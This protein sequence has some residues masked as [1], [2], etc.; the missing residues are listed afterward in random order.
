MKQK[1]KMLV[2]AAA[3]A[4]VGGVW[5]HEGWNGLVYSSSDE[6]KPGE[7][8]SRFIKA[9]EYAEANHVPMLIFWG[10]SSCGIC[11]GFE[12]ALAGTSTTG[13][14]EEIKRISDEFYAWLADRQYIMTFNI[15][16]GAKPEYGLYK[17]DCQKSERF[18]DNPKS[19]KLPTMAIYWPTDEQKPACWEKYQQKDKVVRFPGRPDY[20]PFHTVA[21]QEGG[22]IYQLM[23]N[24]DKF[25]GTYSPVPKYVGGMFTAPEDPNN[26]LECEDGTPAIDIELTRDEK[27]AP[28]ETNS[29]LRA[30][31]PDGSVTNEIPVSW[32]SNDVVQVVSVDPAAY[33]CAA[34]GEQI[35]L[36]MVDANGTEWATN[37]ITYVK[38][39]NGAG[40]PLW[41]TE[42]QAPASDAM[43]LRAESSVPELDYGEWTMDLEGAKALV[44]A[45]GGH[46]LVSIQGSLWC[47]DCAN[48]DRNF[49]DVVGADGT[50]VVRKWAKENKVALV[51]I[52]IP[53]FTSGTND[54]EAAFSSPCLL[55][56]RAAESQL[57]YELPEWGFYDVSLGGAPEDLAQPILRSGLGYQTRKGIS[58]EEALAK[59]A[60]FRELVTKNTDE[61]GFHRPEDTKAYRT[62]VPIFVLLRPSDNS[63]AARFTR[64][65]AK[66]PYMYD[67]SGKLIATEERTLNVLKRF[68]EMI[69]I[70]DDAE[71]DYNM[72]EVENNYPHANSPAVKANGG[73]VEAQLCN[74][75]FEDSFRLDGFGGAG[76]QAV[77]V[78]SATSPAEVKVEILKL[79]E[80]G[81]A[82]V[83]GDSATGSLKDAGVSLT[84]S[85]P[86]QGVYFVRV[87][88]ADI[89]SDEFAAESS[90]ATRF[91]DYKIETTTTFTPGEVRTEGVAP[92][93]SNDVIV[94]FREDTNTLYRIDG[95][96]MT[97]AASQ[98]ALE[99]VDEEKKLF[100]ATAGGA[101]TITLRG[102]ETGSPTFVYQV[103]EPGTV[104]FAAVKAEINE[105]DASN[106]VTIVRS[107]LSGVAR[108]K[109]SVDKENSDYYYDYGGYGTKLLPRFSI[110]G[111]EALAT[112]F[113]LTLPEGVASTNFVVEV[114]PWQFGLW[115]GDGTVAFKVACVDGGDVTEITEGMG[116]F[117]LDVKENDTTEI[118]QA[119]IVG[120]AD[121]D[122]DLPWA[123][124]RTVYAR[125]GGEV[126]LHLERQDGWDNAVAIA[127]ASGDK[128]VTLSG[129]DGEYVATKAYEGAVHWPTHGKEEPQVDRYVTV[130]NLP[131]KVGSSVKVTLSK[132]NQQATFLPAKGFETITIVTTEAE[133]PEFE[134]REE[135]FQ[136]YLYAAS[137]NVVNYA[138]DTV[139]V[140]EKLTYTK[141][142]GSLPSGI[143]AKPDPVSKG[144]AFFGVPKKAGTYNVTYQISETYA[145]DGARSKT[146]KGLVVSVT[147]T[148]TDVSV[149][150]EGGK[151]I[152]PSITSSRTIPDIPVYA[153]EDG[154]YYL[155]GTLK[156]T[157]PPKGNV[158]AKYNCAS[159]S[160]SF[161]A[162]NWSAT[163][164]DF[165]KDGVLEANLTTS[166]KGYALTVF[167]NPD[168][169][170]DAEL[171]DPA[172][173]G[174][175]T[176]HTDGNIWTK[177][178]T[179]KSKPVPANTAEDWKGYYTVSLF[180]AGS[181]VLNKD[182]EPVPLDGALDE[183]RPNVAPT[184]VGYLTLKMDTSSAWNSGTVK[185]AGLLPNGETV[186]G[187]TV[188]SRTEYE[189]EGQDW[190]ALPIFYR[191]SK[192]ILSTVALICANSE[193][194]GVRRCVKLPEG[195]MGHWFHTEKAVAKASYD[196][197]M[198]LFGS[199]Y[200]KK[201]SLS[202]CCV[203]DQL[204]TNLV[205]QTDIAALGGWVYG[206][207]PKDVNPL[208]LSVSSNKI[209]VVTQAADNPN[210]V[211][212][213]LARDTGIV[214]GSFN[215]KY[216][217]TATGKEKSTTATW[218]GV[219]L[220]GWGY[221]C[222]CAKVKE[223]D[224]FLP[225][226]S[227]AYYFSDKVGYK[228]KETA[229]KDTTLNVK[230]GGPAVAL[231]K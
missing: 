135:S 76:K 14:P 42:R 226:V 198:H 115:F 82:V 94:E 56:R 13:D 201:A 193:E 218:K 81:K 54:L 183:D 26:R 176:A 146:F 5:A 64:F 87:S 96:D 223:D 69:A 174:K 199:Y 66:S 10:E 219:V 179:S 220:M 170:V 9:K 12:K 104:G 92:E 62:G 32:K 161:S 45:K 116:D 111:Q 130:S 214:S 206:G 230:R 27:C 99:V 93:G 29:T 25:C 213:S 184:G 11:Q 155:A 126:T 160:V 70:A 215:L 205:F 124:S 210:A 158:S 78:S 189:E 95:V 140:G 127:I 134:R 164:P 33:N 80:T 28:Y 18:T 4:V 173:D 98:A 118:G 228:A 89:T 97:A 122:G 141:L 39:E 3:A 172:Y 53:D 75:D 147:F 23:R 79:D 149:A 101:Q 55:S 107:N 103:W 100:R 71:H 85:I 165:L 133:G 167:V 63:V 145:P 43:N 57:A 178:S 110:A 7:I 196:M 211:K 83:V 114:D 2:L 204:T 177:G 106:V 15:N 38:K 229:T 17:E 50:N 225:F 216:T 181:M 58:N 150:P 49:L 166:K 188:L 60:E 109:V 37:H 171:L 102:V 34:D 36:I 117:R 52:D 84:N 202:E 224:K 212:F 221:G 169:S 136:L 157:I 217:D 105:S 187:S 121:A 190:A 41:K 30:I 180:P 77:R 24:M 132:F 163:G 197:D 208:S 186:S 154:F 74:A 20:M 67:E 108:V 131:A 203:V 48:T 68:E 31:G 6:I 73:T 200:D 195:V 143:S 40:N 21:D 151:P 8:T 47:H 61:G 191:K 227:G 19:G 112:E 22:R 128:T 72:T 144:L 152:N 44:A 231:A 16:T 222:G 90:N 153:H 59:L 207:A 119:A 91:V 46:V 162:K 120:A 123:K 51:S 192:D 156:L 138:A 86:E 125:A 65:A 182:G 175:L 139:V 88:G 35:T 194:E 113:E 142:A 137:S 185:W 1:I 209:S 168:Y 159:G 129:K 148:V